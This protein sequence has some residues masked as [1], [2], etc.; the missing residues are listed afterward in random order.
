MKEKIYETPRNVEIEIVVEQAVLT[1]SGEPGAYPGWN[2]DD[3]EIEL[4]GW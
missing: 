1:A 3:G 4:F 2:N